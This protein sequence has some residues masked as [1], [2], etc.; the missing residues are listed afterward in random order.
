[1]RF[2]FNARNVNEYVDRRSLV[3]ASSEERN[4]LGWCEK[5]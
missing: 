2:I 5:E 4:I 1:M 3:A